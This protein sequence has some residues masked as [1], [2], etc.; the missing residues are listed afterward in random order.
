MT[1]A[2]VTE[3]PTEL[4]SVPTMAELPRQ[5]Y[6]S[7]ILDTGGVT[8]TISTQIHAHDCTDADVADALLNTVLAVCGLEGPG[9]YAAMQRAIALH[10]EPTP[11]LQVAPDAAPEQPVDELPADELPADEPE[12]ADAAPATEAEQLDEPQADEL[13]QPGDE[14]TAVDA[15]TA[16]DDG[17]EQAEPDGPRRRR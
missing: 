16:E 7:V 11:P 10:V 2:A 4:T 14:P 17:Q 5:P 6:V 13:D 9:A 15:T 8:R 12:P 1:A 3:L